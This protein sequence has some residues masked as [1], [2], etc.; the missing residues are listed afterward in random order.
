METKF[1]LEEFAKTFPIGELL[2]LSHS[3]GLMAQCFKELF[4][5]LYSSGSFAHLL[6][7]NGKLFARN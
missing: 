5:E 4:M 2:S 1:H 3:N 7:H 6:A